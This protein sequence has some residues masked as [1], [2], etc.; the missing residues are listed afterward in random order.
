[1]ASVKEIISFISGSCNEG[2]VDGE[3]IELI[4]II[5]SFCPSHHPV[6]KLLTNVI[7]ILY[8]D[9]G[10]VVLVVSAIKEH[11]T[12]LMIGMDDGKRFTDY[13]QSLMESY[14][15]GEKSLQL[16]L[17]QVVDY[18]IIL[19]QHEWDK[20]LKLSQLSDLLLSI[21]K[22]ML[23]LMHHCQWLINQFVASSDNVVV[24]DD[25]AIIS[26]SDVRVTYSTLHCVADDVL[27][28][29][30]RIPRDYISAAAMVTVVAMTTFS[31][32]LPTIP[33]KCRNEWFS[34]HYSFHSQLAIIHGL[35]AKLSPSQLV[36]LRYNDISLLQQ[37]F[38]IIWTIKD[39]FINSP[40]RY[41]IAR[42]ISLWTNMLC[43]SVD[44]VSFNISPTESQLVKL[45]LEYIWSHWEDPID[46]IRH[47]CKD[48]FDHLV[49][50]Y[51]K[52]NDSGRQCESMEYLHSLSV[53]LLSISSPSRGKYC[54]LSSLIPH[55]NVKSIMDEWPHLPIELL[56][57]MECQMIACRAGELWCKLVQSHY[58]VVSEDDWIEMWVV[59]I[60]KS[61]LMSSP[62]SKQH[63]KQYCISSLFVT[64]T[65]THSIIGRVLPLI[66]H[67]VSCDS[68]DVLAVS[69]TCLECSR[70]NRTQSHDD[71]MVYF[72]ILKSAII[73]GNK[74]IVSMS[75]HIM[76]H[77]SLS[78]SLPPFDYLPL[79]LHFLSLHTNSQSPWFRQEIINSLKHLFLRIID[80]SYKLVKESKK[81]REFDISKIDVILDK[82]K[83]FLT[84]L[85]I[86]CFS[87]LSHPLTTFQRR[88]FSLS[89]L[90][91]MSDIFS[92]LTL[93][94]FEFSSLLSSDLARNLIYVLWDTFDSNRI[95][96]LKLLLNYDHM[97]SLVS[98]SFSVS[99]S[100]VIIHAII[101]LFHCIV[102]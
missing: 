55:V 58:Q 22:V 28:H 5:Q 23:S 30:E 53:C 19:A 42:T 80:G 31:N 87:Y 56:N 67:D 98:S 65:N 29:G 33:S 9:K 15:P 20:Y 40:D 95:L 16:L 8:K 21:L 47:Q 17:P 51:I 12:G 102:R 34:S 94:Q 35:L 13:I 63:I 100:C 79:I 2:I 60:L 24:M 39:N 84:Q 49:D 82:Y 27:K 78:T 38:H 89:I 69:L 18:F 61:L 4:V 10:M 72:D 68:D 50:A 46:A 59:P 44:V 1:M 41:S 74:Q 93:P 101:V 62:S 45:L 25:G 71:E 86:S 43:R 96:A 37:L 90:S 54:L 77:S 6:K 7:N 3:I 85:I 83:E 52:L 99:A 97:K 81:K 88:F 11:I 14:P 48:T 70:I 64:C 92:N 66:S 73:H 57:N 91:L 26:W 36:S 32:L 76:C 75:F